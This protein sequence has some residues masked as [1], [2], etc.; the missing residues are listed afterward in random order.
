MFFEENENDA[1]EKERIKFMQ[2]GCGQWMIHIFV[3]PD[4]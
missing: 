4:K 1:K 3:V 2:G